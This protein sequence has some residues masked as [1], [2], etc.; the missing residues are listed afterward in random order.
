[1]RDIKERPT[2][3][4]PRVMDSAARAP[5]KLARRSLLSAKEQAQ[6]TAAPQQRDESPTEYAE[7]RVERTGEDVARRTGQEVTDRGKQLARKANDARKQY[8]EAKQRGTEQS[9]SSFYSAESNTVRQGRKYARKNAQVSRRT[10]QSTPQSIKQ[11]AEPSKTAAK[12]TVKTIRRGVKAAQYTVKTTERTVKTTQHA[13]KAAQKTAQ[14]TAKAAQTAGRTA[15]L[16]AKAAVTTAKAA[17]KTIAA[18]IK[19]IISAIK[20][21]IAAIAAGGWVA[22]V[23]AVLAVLVI[24]LLSLFGVFSANEA[25]DGDKPMTEAIEAINTEFKDEIESKIAELTAQG[26]ADIVEI[27]YEGD[28]E[29]IESAVPNWADVIGVY[30]IKIG[31]D[32]ENPSD[33]TEMSP[34]NM[35]KLREIFLDMNKVLYRTESET[36]TVIVTDKYGAIVLDK[37]GKPITERKTTLFIYVNVL[38]MDYRDGA[39]MYRFN[40][41]QYEMLTELMQPDYYPLFA[42]LLGDTIG[43]GGT[44]GFGLDINPDLPSTE[45]GAQ[46]VSAAKKYIGHSYSSMD[47]SGLV[48]AAY[49][50]CGLSS[51]NGLASTGMAQKCRDM[52]VLFTDASKLQAGDLIFFARKDASRGEGY[53]TDIQRCGTGKCKRWMQIHHVAIYINGEFLIDSTGGNNSVQIRKHW[54]RSGSEWKWV[55]FG[56]PT[57]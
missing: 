55:C 6:E 23:I 15:Q 16:A 27:I 13:A 43:D 42:E 45:L 7:S 21:L 50:D 49:R 34:E 28:M 48:R 39:D 8:K 1:M 22:I 11:S 29:S 44:Y 47:C 54:G 4:T 36:E 2:D 18:I 30:A 53:C 14:A 46:I 41:D 3:R 24:A 19:A 31:A 20:E 17:A 51:M 52:N 32:A 56:R 33:V 10:A 25:A 5:K 57:S 40:A 26:A 37:N 9:R 38:S 12:E 35:E